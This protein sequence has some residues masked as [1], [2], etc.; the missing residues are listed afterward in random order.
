MTG[1]LSLNY[2][3]HHVELQEGIIN[4]IG[5]ICNDTNNY[6]KNKFRKD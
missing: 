2:S 6:R 3:Q 4:D 1:L 5:V